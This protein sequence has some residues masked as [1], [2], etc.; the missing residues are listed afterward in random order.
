MTMNR[1]IHAAVR[2]DLDR[3]EA[4]LRTFPDGDRSR[5]AGLLRGWDNLD[6]QLRK[7]HEQEDELIWPMLLQA[8]VDAVLLRE[9]EEEH[10][11]M[12]DALQRTDAAMQRFG[13]AAT[14]S[15]ALTAA[16]SMVA[17]QVVVERH[18]Q[19][20]EQ[21]LEPAL[22]PHL[23][24]PEWR[25]VEKRLRAGSPVEGGRMFAWLLD[26][27]GPDADGFLRSMV[28]RPVLFVLSRVLG[29]GYHRSIAP[30]WRT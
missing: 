28:P 9:M 10:Q 23:E 24:T 15:D 17:T 20:E 19:H 25:A 7:H 12:A 21:E 22:R 26:G 2:R 8:G 13:S 1:V 18:L 30:V 29:R 16:D 11:Q 27:S 14:R 3:L 5:A 6:A 4:A